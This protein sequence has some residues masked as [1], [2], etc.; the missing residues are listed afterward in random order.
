MPTAGRARDL[1][2][3]TLCA[4]QMHVYGVG[5]TSYLT[6]YDSYPRAISRL[7]RSHRRL[8][9]RAKRMSDHPLL[10]RRLLRK[11]RP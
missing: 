5:V 8:L 1:A 4:G 2:R 6:Q 3:K 9:H 7:I 10:C 11:S